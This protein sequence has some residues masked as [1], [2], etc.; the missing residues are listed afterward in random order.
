MWVRANLLSSLPLSLP[1]TLLLMLGILFLYF[2]SVSG[3]PLRLS[4]R[5]SVGK[6]ANKAHKRH[7]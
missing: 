5:T 6:M 2:H 4:P 3:V 7:G 1:L